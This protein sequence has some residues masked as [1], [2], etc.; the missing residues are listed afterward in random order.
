MS[1]GDIYVATCEMHVSDI[2]RDVLA[3]YNADD[4]ASFLL[5]VLTFLL[6]MFLEIRTSKGSVLSI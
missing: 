1:V 4:V 6:S 3:L 2:A 5:L